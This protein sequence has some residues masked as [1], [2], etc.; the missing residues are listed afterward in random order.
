MRVIL[1]IRKKG[2][3]ILPKKLR[4]KIEVKEGDSIIAEVVENTIVLRPLTPKI[5]DIDPKFVEEIL[6]EEAEMEKRKY[7]EIFK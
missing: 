6:K 3:I 5:V 1:K 2:I 4:E 7:E